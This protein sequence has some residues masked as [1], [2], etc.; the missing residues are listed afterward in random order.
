[1]DEGDME[2]ILCVNADGCKQVRMRFGN[3]KTDIRKRI[4]VVRYFY[5]IMFKKSSGFRRFEAK[6]GYFECISYQ[7]CA[8]RITIFIPFSPREGLPALSE[9]KNSRV[10]DS[11]FRAKKTVGDEP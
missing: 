8:R 1:M 7:F 10:S 2:T 6:I 5:K 3:L 9:H 11:R 4:A